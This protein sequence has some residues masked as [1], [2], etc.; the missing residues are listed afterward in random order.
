[1]NKTYTQ[2]GFA[3]QGLIEKLEPYAG[4]NGTE[5]EQYLGFRAGIQF[6]IDTIKNEQA[7]SHS[8]S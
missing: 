5:S 7:I 6:A 1:M 8:R 2:Y 3:L 4:V